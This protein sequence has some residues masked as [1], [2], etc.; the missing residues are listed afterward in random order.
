[1]G[2]MI[3]TAQE[4]EKVLATVNGME[5]VQSE[6]DFI[7]TS[8]VLP[9]IQVQLQGQE[10][11]AEQKMMI[12]NNILEQLIMQKLLLE[13]AAQL[14]VTAD[15]DILN[16]QLETAK[17]YMPDADADQ[18]KQLLANDLMAQEVVRQEVVSKLS[19]SDEEAQGYY[20]EQS[21]QFLEPEQVQAS[22]ILV[23]VEPDASQEDKDVARKKIDDV[24]VKATSGEDFAELAKE[25]SEGPSKDNGG[26]LG[27]FGRGQ[28]VPP[29]EEAV[30]AL[31]EGEISDVVETQ[32]G[33]HIIKL[34]G[35]KAERQAPFEEVEEQIR[36]S[37]LDQKINTEV[38]AWITDLRANATVEMLNVEAAPDEST[39]TE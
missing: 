26:D 31:E 22:H 35:R 30:F 34:T 38:N 1:M 4:T 36:Q 10:L 39:K 18:L 5:V 14:N 29:F 20:D 2:T 28:M 7:F 19:V 23:M 24:L 13:R 37:L 21:E 27:F 17:Q 3:A 32:F 33:Y 6:V 12:E 9:Q 8:I 25:F 11:P 16:Q 15:Q